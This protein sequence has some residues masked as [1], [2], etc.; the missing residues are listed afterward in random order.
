MILA[1]SISIF[2]QQSKHIY[3]ANDDHTDLFWTADEETY[4]NAFIEM[5]D[6][7]LDLADSTDDE[8]SEHQS[9]W[10]CDGSFWLWTYEKNKS[11]VEFDRL[12]NRIRDGHIS[13]PLNALVVCEGGA[14]AEAILRGMYYAGQLE[15]RFN[16]RF[17]MAIAM[18][19]QTLSY[20]LPT[21]WAGAGASYSWK[22]ICNCDTRVSQAWNRE[23]E[24]YWHEGLDG[25]RILMKW[26]SMLQN[27]RSMGGY[28]EARN[29]SSVVDY[30]DSNT[31]FQSRY[32]YD[33]I[34]AFGKGW[35]NLKTLTDEF[36][37]VAKEKTNLNRLV[38]VSNMSDFFQ[39]FSTLYGESLPTVSVS[40]G[41]EWDLYCASLAEVSAQVKRAVE[42]LRG[43]EALAALVALEDSGF[44]S[45]RESSRDQTWMD[46]GLFWEHNFGMADPPSG[47]TYER[48]DWQRRLAEEIDNYVDHLYN[49]A[50]QQLG[51]MIRKNGSD[52]RFYVF[53]QLSW[54][55]NDI[56]E[57]QY[58]NS[59]PFHVVDISSEE[60]VPWEIVERDNQSYLR[61]L[62]S[63]IPA[64]GYKVYEVREGTSQSFTNA[65]TVN[66]NIIE[67]QFCQITFSENGA[68][69]SLI[70]KTQGNREYVQNI[71]SRYV[72]DLGTASGSV[73]LEHEGPVTVTLKAVS[74]DPLVHTTRLTLIRDLERISLVNEITQNFS[75]VY[76]W[77]FGFNINSPDVWHEEVG[78]VIRAKT[79]SQG[80]HYSDREQNSR[81]DWLTLNHFADM[82][83]AGGLGI[84]LSNADCYF[85]RLGS[86][87]VGG[88]DVSTPRISVLVGGKVGGSGYGLPNQGGDSYFLQRFA[89]QTHDSYNAVSAMKFALEH[90]NPFITGEI[91]G[92]EIY[93]E[94]SYSLLSIDNP[95]VL[96]W[97]LKPAEDGIDKGIIT[98]IWNLDNQNSNFN[99]AFPNGSISEASQVTHTE[100]VYGNAS[101][102]G[103]TLS[104]SVS[105]NQLKTYLV[106]Y[107]QNI[108][109][110]I[111]SLD[112]L[113]PDH[114][115]LFQNYPNP[116]NSSTTVRFQLAKPGYVTLNIYNLLGQKIEL[117]LEGY[118]FTGE[119]KIQWNAEYIP[120]GI[121]LIE[122][123][124]NGTT[125]RKK[126]VIVR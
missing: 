123:R 67:N 118:K 16:L 62:A 14:P 117:L 27:S 24:I 17:S 18:E 46:L 20:G 111:N 65:A 3:I 36:V 63:N 55:R 120:S 53:N 68:V 30:V 70:D 57:I 12:I 9:R 77:S 122:L 23:N 89:L 96:L 83:E 34:G 74:S 59:G 97:A 31:E 33:I 8:I 81:Y 110:S 93:P 61:I 5:I 72:N 51:Q 19:N 56:A 80:G 48:I 10:N 41:N 37:T 91:I 116:F 126:L 90:Q 69:T 32:P 39:E 108:S 100:T 29:P 98:R 21:L 105:G 102:S 43:A 49:D 92:G 76:T 15:R 113:Y 2:S 119:Y 124:F 82:S 114:F 115:Q 125:Q 73:T 52:F 99:L 88:L 35:D 104:E 103:N 4:R 11:Q 75:D 58:T 71:A 26:N 86:S 94:F 106:N 1:F 6:Y 107:Q 42:K 60:E 87:T 84:T 112:N 50:A 44:M 79:E 40:F 85:M 95:D 7:Y 28:A 78:A 38:I 109:N 54:P 45:G 25:S 22:G 101:F 66:D 13:A 64:V 121:Y 47:L